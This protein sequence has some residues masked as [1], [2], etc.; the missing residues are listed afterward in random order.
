MGQY[1]TSLQ[2][3]H[4]TEDKFCILLVNNMNKKN[5]KILLEFCSEYA[6]KSFYFILF[7]FLRLK[8]VLIPNNN[9]LGFM[10]NE[11]SDIWK[12]GILDLIEKN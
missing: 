9:I 6:E 8:V 2:G 4:K 5:I 7:I 1:S 10:K 3:C 12:Y 11:E